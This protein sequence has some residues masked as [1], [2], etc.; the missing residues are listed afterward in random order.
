M[1]AD[2]VNATGYPAIKNANKKSKS[3]KSKYQ[4]FFFMKFKICLNNSKNKKINTK[5]KNFK[6]KIFKPPLSLE[7]L[8]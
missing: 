2:K 7:L 6:I 5:I 1:A 8:R 3:K 4:S